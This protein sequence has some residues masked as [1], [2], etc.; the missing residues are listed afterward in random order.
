M[1]W[2]PHKP[3]YFN[4][5]LHTA[6][7]DNHALTFYKCLKK[8]N[9]NVRQKLQAFYPVVGIGSSHP[10]LTRK[11]L[12]LHPFGSKGVNTLPCAGGGGG[13]NSDDGTDALVL[14]VYYN[15]PTSLNLLSAEFRTFA[16]IWL[17]QTVQYFLSQFPFVEGDSTKRSR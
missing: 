6:W 14:T 12:L 2:V 10:I 13:P 15:P 4:P 16:P 7:W 1:A 3:L 5:I 11:R 8:G 17:A 9:L